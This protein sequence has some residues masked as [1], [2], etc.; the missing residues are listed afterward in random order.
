MEGTM[1][2]PLAGEIELE[3]RACSALLPLPR[4]ALL[5]L[6]LGSIAMPV[7]MAF[8]EGM[9]GHPIQLGNSVLSIAASDELVDALF[10]DSEDLEAL[11]RAEDQNEAR[12]QA[13]LARD[14]EAW[15][16]AID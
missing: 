8:T 3:N 15:R 5:A 4:H 10:A 13:E 7:A 2:N 11:R 16:F 14:A 12:V 6:A 9:V 1:S